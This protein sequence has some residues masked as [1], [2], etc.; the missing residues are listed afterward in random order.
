MLLT[1]TRAAT[2]LLVLGLCWV[3]PTLLL[4]SEGKP[5][6]FNI[7]GTCVLA[8]IQTLRL[9][10]FDEPTQG[11]WPYT[12]DPEPYSGE[13]T[14]GVTQGVGP[15]EPLNGQF[16]FGGHDINNAN[17]G[18]RGNNDLIFEPVDM[19]ETRNVRIRFYYRAVGFDNGDDLKYRLTYDGVLQDEVTFF[20]G[21]ADRSTD[22]WEPHDIIIPNGVGIFQLTVSAVQNGNDY[23][24]LDD[25]AVIAN[26]IDDPCSLIGLEDAE[27]TCLSESTE[28]GTDLFRISIRYSG[29]DDDA[30]LVVE[31]GAT[32]P[33]RD[34]TATT[35]NLG[36]DFTTVPDGTLILENTAGEFEEGD[37][38]QVSIFDGGGDCMLT[39]RISTTENRCSNTCDINISVDNIRFGCAANTEGADDGRARIRFTNGP[40]PGSVLSF[41]DPD[42]VLSGDDPA[43]DERGTILAEGLTEGERYTLTISGGGCTGDE[44]LTV[45]FDFAAGTCISGP[46]VI[47]E[48][49]FD[50]IA[51]SS[52][53]AARDANG[54]GVTSGSSDEF[55]ELFNSSRAPVDLSG[56]LLA[57]ATGILHEFPEGTILPPGTALVIFAAAPTTDLGCPTAGANRGIPGSLGLNNGG[58]EVT[59]SNPA[60][61][62]VSSVSWTADAPADQSL[63]RSP[64]FSG[65]LVGHLGITANPIPQSACQFNAEP[66]DALPVGLTGFRAT[67]GE[68]EVSLE[69]ETED[70][71][72]N[73]HFL[74]ERSA[75][76]S[77]WMAI[78]RVASQGDSTGEYLYIDTQPAVGVNYYRLR[79]V[80]RSGEERTYGPV[81]VRFL[82]HRLTVYPNPARE[83]LYLSRPVPKDA[84]AFIWNANG[85]LMGRLPD[86]VGQVDLTAYPAGIYVLRLEQDGEVQTT[87]FLKP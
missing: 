38:V 23:F 34:V 70:E 78:G 64:D 10:D 55:V 35:I 80:D 30:V 83:T 13:D 40:E 82:S 57:E 32:T 6:S 74:I 42:V 2:T 25:F 3:P 39:Q 53:D 15:I 65:P 22:D 28:P 63:A 41:S 43:T 7:A 71:R 48:V 62:I 73:K 66:F 36:D 12:S 18:R 11:S 14:W 5:C 21:S 75:D 20:E 17:G 59:L 81:S 24:G 79:Q 44:A 37:E 85:Q 84:T 9:Q 61:S 58:D 87:R 47:N 27:I 8:Q 51:G 33:A 69:W 16:F 68:K 60:G 72:H 46:V 29:V 45:P 4:P 52:T 1:F 86:G 77:G 67:A 76:G 49:N 50:P 54:D 26:D 31:A 19:S 56:Y